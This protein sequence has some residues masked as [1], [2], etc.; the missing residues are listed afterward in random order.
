MQN[1]NFNDISPDNAA[2]LEQNELSHHLSQQAK[3]ADRI[4]FPELP[5]EVEYD[6]Q[7]TPDAERIITSFV[8]KTFDQKDLVPLAESL[9]RAELFETFLGRKFIGQK[10]F[11]LEGAQTL[12]PMLE[13]ILGEAAKA[14]A[15]EIV[16]GMSHRGRLNVLANIFQKPLREIF[17]EFAELGA[18]GQNQACDVRYHKGY[19][20]KKWGTLSLELL[21]NPSHLES[22]DPVLEGYVR[23]RQEAKKDY[24]RKKVVPLLIHG[25]AAFAG[26]GVVYET[27][28]FSSLEGWT[29]G[30]TI[31]I[32]LNNHIGFTANPKE[33][34]SSKRVTDIAKGFGFPTIH[35]NA[36]EVEHASIAARLAYELRHELGVDVLLDLDCTRTHG[37]NESDEPAFTQPLMYEKIRAQKTIAAT[38]A[39]KV[40]FDLAQFS[41]EYVNT[42]E[43]A[44][45][46]AT[47]EKNGKT[48]SRNVVEH[49]T[50]ERLLAFGRSITSVPEGIVLHKKLA[51]SLNERQARLEEEKGNFLVDW[52][53]AEALA[54]ATLLEQGVSVRLT[55]QDTKRGTFSQRHAALIDQKTEVEYRPLEHIANAQAPFH[56]Y[57]SLL[58]EFGALGFEYGYSL[59]APS[60]L[61]LWEAQYGD[62]ANG[63][64]VI[65]DQYIASGAAKWDTSSNLVLLLPHGYEGQGPEHSSGRIER[66]LELAAGDNMAIANPTEPA[67]YFHLLLE[68]AQKNVPLIIF[69]PKGLLRHPKCKSPLHT[70]ASG[71]FV[72][73]LVDEIPNAEKIV[74]CQGRI[75]YDL[76][77]VKERNFSIVRI[78]QLYPLNVEKIRTLLD[79]SKKRIW[80]QEE[81]QNGGAW[82]A[83]RDKVEGLIYIGRPESATPA[84]GF[85]AQHR[86][87]MSEII[88][89]VRQA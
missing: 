85:I 6:P 70:L 18:P 20:S 39:E 68:Q 49:P 1:F 30:G 19:A 4:Q 36:C 50:L 54:F 31:H 9:A 48:I 7:V 63:A 64:Q 75:Y 69:T 38:Y 74:L 25:D 81:P 47:A 32:I 28:Q 34:C 3:K 5:F 35:V 29:T 87:E 84:T 45:A 27:A 72:D 42:L 66:F 76:L 61:T 59:G 80:L 82:H 53:F 52:A 67:Q 12:V 83:I 10:R 44:Q 15:D 79:R 23:A 40:G 71:R 88:N 60:A 46:S 41:A 51:K 86:A 22:I 65:I 56:I 73:I 78:E 43:A 8:T 24:S 33:Y 17:S 58:S 57:N 16:C 11:S 21:S 37:H 55:G 77:D 13:Q 2:F 89:H 26:Q 62:F 14:G